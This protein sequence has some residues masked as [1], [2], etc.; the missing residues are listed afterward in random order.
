MKR[1]RLDVLADQKG[2]V[3]RADYVN[4]PGDSSS[5]TGSEGK[6]EGLLLAI[7][8]ELTISFLFFG[9]C[10]YCISPSRSTKIKEM[11]GRTQ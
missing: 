9:L 6:D 5:R 8:M 1:K 3:R 7:V 4:D 10:W 2:N 11:S